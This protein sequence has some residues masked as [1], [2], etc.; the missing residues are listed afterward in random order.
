ML[1]RRL[2]RVKVMQIV[3]AQTVATDTVDYKE[4]E[5]ELFESITEA[6]KLYH[7]FLLLPT[8]LRR[9]A[10][11]RIDAAKSKL[12]PSEK[13]LNPNTKFVNNRLI[14]Q[15]EENDMLCKYAE[16]NKLTWTDDEDVLKSIFSR[17]CES[18][19]YKN[20]MASKEDSFE[21]D[22]RFVLKFMGKE[23]PQYDFI[24]DSLESKSVYWNDEAEF[25]I[26]IALKTLKQFTADNGKTLELMPRLKDADD[27]KFVKVLLQKCLA[28]SNN[29]IALIKKYS[30][31][32]DLDR[33][34]TLD[35]TIICL[36]VAEMISFHEIPIRVTLNEYLE[37]SKFYSTPK[38]HVY[39]NGVLEKI[40]RQLVE[41]KQISLSQIK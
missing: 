18:D 29:T 26:S 2:L 34:A 10:E 16:Q 15:I 32:W 14:R 31:N 27:E 35:I 20:Y 13:E 8:E 25:V 22:S 38:S 5:N 23:M 41:E 1:S 9:L 24:F 6:H 33:V 3:Y 28:T 21:N 17:M 12:R 11:K 37:L 4:A 40:V 30:K 36:A 19:F 7:Y 39:I